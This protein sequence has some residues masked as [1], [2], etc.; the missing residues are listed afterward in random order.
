MDGK[1]KK[2]RKPEPE[3]HVRTQENIRR[4][5]ELAEKGMAELEARRKR[6]AQS[7]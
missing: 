1:R 3:W 4:M 7:G 2:S 5:R 6:E